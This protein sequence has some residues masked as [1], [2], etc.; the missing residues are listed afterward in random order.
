[1]FDEPATPVTIALR[2]PGKWSEPKELVQRLP[3]G[4]RLTGE[5]LVLPDSAKI[6]FGA[7][8]PDDQFADIFRSSCRNT[9]TDDELAAVDAYQ[10]NLTL[11]GPGG[12]LESA[13][14]MMMAA[15]ALIRAGGV[16]VFIDNSGVAHG[17]R[18]WLELTEDG[19]P[20]ALSFAFV[21]IVGGD[22]EIYTMGM[23]AVGRREIVMKRADV[24]RGFDIIDVIRYLCDSDKPVDD[25]HVIA[26]LEGPRFQV[27][28]QEASSDLPAGSPFYNPFGQLRLVSFKDIVEK[29]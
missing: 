8:P 4:F 7:L 20:D 23:H 21:A 1:M 11:S 24:E 3:E 13:R 15:A 9:P 17:G 28:A 18:Q 19:G 2:I 5:E 22:K 16:G 25:G 29:N 6:E 14:T 26:D 27:V 10:V 12:S